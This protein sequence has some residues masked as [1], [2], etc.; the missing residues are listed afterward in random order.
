MAGFIIET[1]KAD[2]TNTSSVVYSFVKSHNNAPFVT[3]DVLSANTNVF[4]KDIT[5][6]SVRFET[7]INFTGQVHFHAFSRLGEG[8]VSS[9][10]GGSEPTPTY[11]VGGT[12]SGMVGTGLVLQINGGN[13]LTLNSN[14][15]FTFVPVFTNGETYNVTH[16]S[17][18]SA[19]ETIVITNGAGTIAG[20]NVTNVT[21]TAA[22]TGS[23]LLNTRSLRFDI[24]SGSS[25]FV[26]VKR[27]LHNVLRTKKQSFSFWY[28]PTNFTSTSDTNQTQIIG[29]YILT[30]TGNKWS[31]CHLG[32]AVN[33]SASICFHIGDFSFGGGVTTPNE[34]GLNTWQ[35]VAMVF[36]G[37]L[38]TNKR[39][40]FYKN[41][42]LIHSGTVTT[43]S[44]PQ[45]T[46]IVYIGARRPS[47]GPPTEK[48][49]ITQ[50]AI[51]GNLDELS[52]YTSSLTQADITSIYN[53]GTPQDLL[54]IP[55]ITG[56]MVAWYRFGDANDIVLYP[57]VRDYKGSN[58]GTHISGSTSNYQFDTPPD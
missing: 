56:S 2:F 29:T 32:N 23:A 6:S 21:V 22:A 57:S 7:G 18:P 31:I 16:L 14:G 39:V 42:V 12:L 35:H 11:T 49:N 52:I 51:S 44:F 50:G 9:G 33:P 4:S 40:K 36:D 37:T 55:S 41:G 27:K 53:S 48:V 19:G 8:A 54:T 58:H 38:A 28:K 13:D 15:S 34:F 5:V 10:S 3:A 1:G 45:A 17:G 46:G 26:K 20:A 24:A 47:I 30:S 43:A 25:A